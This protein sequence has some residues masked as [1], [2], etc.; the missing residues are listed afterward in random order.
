MS[1]RD[2]SSIR[3]VGYADFTCANENQPH[4]LAMIV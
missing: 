1:S 3:S 2:W 4:A